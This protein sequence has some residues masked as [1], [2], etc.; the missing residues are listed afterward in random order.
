MLQWIFFLQLNQGR[1]LIGWGAVAPPPPLPR[2]KK[3]EKIEKWRK[4]KR[5]LWI[6]SNYYYKVLFFFKFFNSPVTLKK[7]STPPRKSWNDDP[8]LNWHQFLCL[9]WCSVKRC[10]EIM[11]FQDNVKSFR[12]ITLYTVPNAP[13]PI[14]GPRN[15]SDSLIN[16][17][18]DMSGLALGWSQNLELIRDKTQIM[19]D[20]HSV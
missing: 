5:E 9:T 1:H 3:K 14:S 19:T 17:R 15:N 4:R 20:S 16:L 8:E 10:R 7:K 11:K 2:K 18:L 13:D 12:C 6:T